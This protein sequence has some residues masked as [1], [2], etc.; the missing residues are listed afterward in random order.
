[1]L[2]TGG[3]R[4][5]SRH[6]ARKEVL[7]SSFPPWIPA[8]AWSPFFRPPTKSSTEGH[9]HG[10]AKMKSDLTIPLLKVLQGSS[11]LLESNPNSFPS[12]SRVPQ[13]PLPSRAPTKLGHLTFLLW[14]M[15]C[16]FEPLGLRSCCSPSSECPSFSNKP[17]KFINPAQIPSLGDQ[18]PAQIPFS[19]PLVPV[20]WTS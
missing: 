4:A 2:R 12:L 3:G 11:L 8:Y 7:T 17:G 15:R 14:T 6:S 16:T 9:Q 10:L 13:S 18:D 1:M 20:N 19:P 5:R